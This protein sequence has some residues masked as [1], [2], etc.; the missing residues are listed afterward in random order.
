METHIV[1]SRD[2]LAQIVAEEVEEAINRRLPPAIR[3]ATRPRYYT[4]K[5]VQE[6][7]GWSARS[8][9]YKRAERQIPF[10][11]RG[12]KILYPA[13]E[14]HEWIE[15]GYVPARTEPEGASR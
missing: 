11:K 4:N 14:L 10:I 7:T 12:R 3:S 2:E 15:Q 8:L 6:L 13:D 1:T 5:K 9:A